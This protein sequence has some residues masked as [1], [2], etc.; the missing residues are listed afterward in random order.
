[1]AKNFQQKDDGALPHGPLVAHRETHLVIFKPLDEIATR[2]SDIIHILKTYWIWI[3]MIF[4]PKIK[5][6]MPEVLE[7]HDLSYHYGDFKKFAENFGVHGLGFQKEKQ[8]HWRL[9]FY[10]DFG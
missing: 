8:S 2:S 9:W 10:F 7:S 6:F 5:I 1:M 4:H 3:F